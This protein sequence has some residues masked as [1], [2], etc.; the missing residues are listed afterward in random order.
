MFIYLLLLF[1][2]LPALELVVL[3]EAGKVIGSL[4]TVFIIVL[5]GVVGAYLAKMQGKITLFKIQQE[6]NQGQVP[7][8]RLMDGLMIFIAGIVL[9]TP[10]FITDTFGFLLLIPWMRNLVKLLFRKRME[11]AI[12][13][14]SVQFHTNGQRSQ[15]KQSKYKDI[16]IQ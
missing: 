2:I 7:A 8:E 11:A 13:S 14:G 3:I 12:K 10:G 5:T 15:P 4:N 16:D 1:T 9:L 6:L